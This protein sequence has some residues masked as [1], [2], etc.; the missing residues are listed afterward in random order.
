MNKVIGIIAIK[1]G[2]GKTS[3][4]VNLGAALSYEFDKKVLIVDANFSAPNLALHFGLADPEITLYDVLS[5]KA[6]VGDAIYEYDKNLHIIPGSMLN[7]RINPFKLREK[8]QKLKELYDVILIDSSPNLNNEILATMLASD[9]LFVVTSPDFPTLSCT[10]HAV[11][12]AKERKTPI[13]GLILNKTRD[14]KFEL[15]LDDIEK[16]TGIPVIAVLKDDAV[17]PESIAYTKPIVIHKPL[18]DISIEY[19]KLAASLIGE[20]YKDSRLFSRIF[21]LFNKKFQKA[22][23]NRDLLREGKLH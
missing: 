3:C 7:E 12:I 4:S 23:L 14:K 21:S 15:T 1:G 22:D 6:K 18:H 2:V 9:E 10:M 5:N 17:I 8:L 13:T 11:K 16:N 20:E 19:K